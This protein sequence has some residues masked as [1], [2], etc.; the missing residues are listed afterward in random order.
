[1]DFTYIERII[2]SVRT[3]L[4]DLSDYSSILSAHASIHL[5]EV[6]GHVFLESIKF[7]WYDTLIVTQ[8]RILFRPERG[9]EKIVME[10]ASFDD[11]LS[12]GEKR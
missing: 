7:S 6:A 10:Y 12:K 3:L 9:R 11:L 5:E 1:M 8:T 4:G 2:A